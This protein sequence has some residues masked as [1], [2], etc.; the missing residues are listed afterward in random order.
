MSELPANW[1][2]PT[3]PEAPRKTAWKPLLIVLATSGVLGL[4]TCAGGLSLITKAGDLGVTLIGVAL[5][6]GLVFLGTAAANVVYFFI[7]LLEK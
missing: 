6:M 5:A 4:I 3:P 7:W 2:P 1:T